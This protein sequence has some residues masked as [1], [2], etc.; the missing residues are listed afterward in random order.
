VRKKSFTAKQRKFHRAK[1]R[2]IAAEF[3]HSRP[4]D[5]EVDEALKILGEAFLMTHPR[6]HPN[7]LMVHN[8][9][10]LIRDHYRGVAGL[11]L[12]TFRGEE[13]FL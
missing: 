8:P 4:S 13:D 5:D 3:G 1:A 12:L 11:P 2:S 10:G 6:H 9:V 7:Y